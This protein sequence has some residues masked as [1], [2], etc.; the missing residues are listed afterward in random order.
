VREALET[1]EHKAHAL[2]A[3][4]VV[5]VQIAQSNFQWNARTTLIGTAVKLEPVAL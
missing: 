3:D 1:L 4:A 5:G 2:G